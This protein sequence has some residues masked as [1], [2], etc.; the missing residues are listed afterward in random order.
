MNEFKV[1]PAI[2]LI[3]G[4]CVRLEKG[5]YSSSKT[6]RQD[7]LEVAKSLEGAGLK[8][9]HIVDLD[10]AKN[11]QIVNFPILEKICSQTA[12]HVDFGGGLKKSEDLKIA[13]ESGASQVSIGFHGCQSRS[14]VSFTHGG[15]WA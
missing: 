10:G 6:Y 8:Y 11:G 13:F 14:I 4:K 2:D 15:V 5:E 12:L 1:I 3:D 7:P 9:L